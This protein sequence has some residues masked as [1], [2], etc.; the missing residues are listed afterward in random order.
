MTTQPAS[1]DPRTNLLLKMMDSADYQSLIKHG[2]VVALRLGKRLYHQGDPIDAVY[3]PITAMISLLVSTAGKRPSLEMATVGSDGVIGA[4]DAIY[5]Q[6]ALGVALVQIPGSALR[7]PIA[8][9][10]SQ[11]DLRPRMVNIFARHLY[12]L[13]RKILYSVACSHNHSME[14]RCAR[15]ILTSHDSAGVD[16]FPLTQDFVSQMLGVRR[17][18]A[19][20]AI[21]AL[22]D[23]GLIKYVR[24][25]VTVLNRVD[26]ESAACECYGAI[27]MIALGPNEDS[28]QP[29]P[30]R[31]RHEHPGSIVPARSKGGGALG[32]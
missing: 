17:A 19:N 15:W 11:I 10:L 18:T 22:K 16:T 26:L 14:M 4:S 2:T 6:G 12:S 24:G 5:G 27:K 29:W 31:E 13:V 25:K 21:G 7:I 28:A 8:S 30:C 1:C 3:F 23:V 20:L 32:P 9:F